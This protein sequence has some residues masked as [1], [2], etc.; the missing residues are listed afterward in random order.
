[1]CY[2]ALTCY[3]KILVWLFILIMCRGEEKKRKISYILA[4]KG[5]SLTLWTILG[6]GHDKLYICKS[7]LKLF[8]FIF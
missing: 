6:L 3:M 5:S 7:D 8:D 1:M 2:K 4:L